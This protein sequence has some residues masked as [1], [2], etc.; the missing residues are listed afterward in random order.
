MRPN[1]FE[2]PQTCTVCGEPAYLTPSDWIRAHREATG[3]PEYLAWQRAELEVQSDIH[4]GVASGTAMD[5]LQLAE[6]ARHK[7][8]RAIID[9]IAAESQEAGCSSTE[10]NA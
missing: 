7:A 9:R 3:T 5:E 10:T 2:L 8:T 1:R 6:A 4:E